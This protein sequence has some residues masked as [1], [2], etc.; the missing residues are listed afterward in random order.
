MTGSKQPIHISKG[1]S[2]LGPDGLW[3]LTKD[4]LKKWPPKP[5]DPNTKTISVFGASNAEFIRL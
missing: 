2:A 5:K 4:Y 1:N 3:Y